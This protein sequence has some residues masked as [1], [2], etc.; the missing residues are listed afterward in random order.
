MGPDPAKTSAGDPRRVHRNARPPARPFDLGRSRI[1]APRRN[2]RPVQ[3]QGD[4]GPTGSWPHRFRLAGTVPRHGPQGLQGIGSGPRPYPRQSPSL[5]NQ[6][7]I[8]PESI[9]AANAIPARRDDPDPLRYPP[10]YHGDG[11]SSLDGR[12]STVPAPHARFGSSLAWPAVIGLFPHA[13]GSSLD[14]SLNDDSPPGPTGAISRRQPTTGP[15]R[16]TGVRSPTPGLDNPP[17]NGYSFRVRHR[18]SLSQHPENGIRD[19][20][21][22][23]S[24]S[25]FLGPQSRR[26]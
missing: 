11:G 22:D 8:A 6:I 21:S 4:K 20:V 26:I 16:I 14:G 10:G 19:L 23:G 9:P 13:T 1:P 5:E 24:L 7:L 18:T 15:H 3:V 17:R 12:P 25:C 2:H